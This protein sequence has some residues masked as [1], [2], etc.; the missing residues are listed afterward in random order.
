MSKYDLL[1]ELLPILEQYEAQRGT[2]EEMTPNAF[3]SWWKDNFMRQP[4]HD[5]NGQPVNPFPGANR[6]SQTMPPE[7]ELTVQAR[8]VQLLV[9]LNKYVKFYLKK[10][11]DG[12][13]IKTTDDFGF[14][15]SLMSAESLTKTELIQRNYVEM[16]SGMEVI[17]RLKRYGFVRTFPDPDDGRATRVALTPKGRQQFF[18]VLPALQQIS[19]LAMGDMNEHERKQLLFLMQKLHLFHKPIFEEEKKST[20]DDIAVGYLR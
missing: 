20:W 19:Q 14:L 7:G 6:P 18:Q 9:V 17:K 2:E 3:L 13:K 1:V 12:H 11:F 15:A 4:I 8:A 10:G 5:E 16:P